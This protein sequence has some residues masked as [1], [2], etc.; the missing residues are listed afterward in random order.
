MGPS[1]LRIAG[2]A[3]ALRRLDYEVSDSG[4]I[5]VTSPEVQLKYLEEIE[6]TLEKLFLKV[7]AALENKRFPLI[8]GGDHSVAI[9]SVSA[10][11]AFERK[12][13]RKVGLI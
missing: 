11:S 1:A 12:S 7:L 4:D 8:L 9:G 5:H 13:G 6:R 3:E 10:A 2:A